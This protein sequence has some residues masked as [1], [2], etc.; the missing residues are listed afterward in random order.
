M[1]K[2]VLTPRIK[3]IL[4]AIV[5]KLDEKQVTEIRVLDVSHLAS[6]TDFFVFGTHLH[7]RH[8]EAVRDA[9]FDL[10]EEKKV[11]VFG[12]EG[13]GTGW[14]ILDLGTILVHLFDKPTRAFY[15]LDHLWL[16]AKEIPLEKLL[17]SS[18]KGISR[19]KKRVPKSKES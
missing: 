18:A 3:G 13:E 17:N 5:K 9:L 8:I 15:D 10:L 4:S 14:Q 16:D 11:R 19:G 12:Q 7:E 2:R 1:G 6:F